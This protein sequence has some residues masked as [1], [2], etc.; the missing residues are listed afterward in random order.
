MKTF[1]N[2]KSQ[3]ENQPAPGIPCNG[4]EQISGKMKTLRRKQWFTTAILSLTVLVLLGFF[5]YIA[6]YKVPVVTLG[7]LLMISSLTVRIAL[8]IFSL[9]TLENLDFSANTSKFKAKIIGYYTNRIKVHFIA[10]PVILA[11]YITGFVILLPSFKASL[12]PG[13]YTY[14]L[15][16]AVVVLFVLAGLIANTI[17]KE[18]IALRELRDRE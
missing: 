18:L 17:K 4:I 9:K 11:L 15:V 10:T 5:F 8:E 16:S 2:L 13:F 1:E 7:L 14:I 3:W 6:A 12:S